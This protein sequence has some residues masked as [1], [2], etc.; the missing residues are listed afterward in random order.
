MSGEI[1][2][3]VIN[4]LSRIE[5]QIGGLRKMIEED[6][7]CIDILTQT[8]AVISALK[9]VEDIVMQNHLETCVQEAMR[10]GEADEREKRIAE[11]MDVMKR[12][13]KHG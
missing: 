10:K 6:R 2:K 12:W 4:R 5:G 13:R 11:V 3:G 9:G 7:Y 1:R 8:S